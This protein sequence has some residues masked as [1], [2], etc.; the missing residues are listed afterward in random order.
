M[1]RR[2][3]NPP[4]AMGTPRDVL[5]AVVAAAAVVLERL[6]SRLVA[7][8]AEDRLSIKRNLYM[9]FA[10]AVVRVMEGGHFW[11]PTLGSAELN[12]LVPG[13]VP[14]AP[15]PSPHPATD[16]GL[17]ARVSFGAS[18]DFGRTSPTR[19]VLARWYLYPMLLR[20]E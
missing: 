20:P 7:T 13:G 6:P 1:S 11:N 16:P 9:S 8:A 15:N 12:G 10:S 3:R 14:P 17:R 4:L 18:E 2:I 19:L 5:Y